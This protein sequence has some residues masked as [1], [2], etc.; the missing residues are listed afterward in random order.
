MIGEIAAMRSAMN[1]T[2]R[3]AFQME[4][5]VLS[6]DQLRSLERA[7]FAIMERW[8]L[9]AVHDA[10]AA[11]A[12][13][14]EMGFPKMQ[15]AV[16]NQWTTVVQPEHRGRGLGKWLKAAMLERILTDCS[17]VR[18]V[19][20]SNLTTN[21]PMLAINRVL[22]FK[23]YIRGTGWQVSVARLRDYL[24]SNAGPPAGDARGGARGRSPDPCRSSD[25]RPAARR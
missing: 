16:A 9:V 19:R 7:L 8:T 23:P 13:F 25:I 10:S 12:G 22:G 5:P 14:T 21:E 4:P 11:I 1:P 2:H 15:P 20:T 3:G 6:V 17:R 18:E 24:S